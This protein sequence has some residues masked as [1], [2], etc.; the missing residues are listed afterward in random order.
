VAA[1][2]A[3]AAAAAVAEVEVVAGVEAEAVVPLV[4]LAPPTAGSASVLALAR[5]LVPARVLVR[6]PAGQ[7]LIQSGTKT[8]TETAIVSVTSDRGAARATPVRT[9]KAPLAGQSQCIRDGNPAR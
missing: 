6:A 1:A 8:A 7:P 3:A 4:P 5:V 9:K 2:A